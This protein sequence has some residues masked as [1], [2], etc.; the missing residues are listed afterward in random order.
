MRLVSQCGEVPHDLDFPTSPEDVRSVF[1]PPQDPGLFR[2]RAPAGNPS[3]L[4][5]VGPS[6]KVVSVSLPF[7]SLFY[8]QKIRCCLTSHPVFEHSTILL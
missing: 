2:K 5:P 4:K 8:T 6:S 1:S 3:V 7:R